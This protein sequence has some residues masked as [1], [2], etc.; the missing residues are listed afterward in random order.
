ML[1]FYR[2][3]RSRV[4]SQ[5]YY[6]RLLK[7]SPSGYWPLWDGHGA[8]ATSLITAQASENLLS[9]GTFET[10]GSTET[11]AGWIDR[12]G[13]GAIADEGSI[14]HA[15]SHACKLTRGDDNNLWVYQ[16]VVV[17]PGDSLALSLW[18]R[19][20]GSVGG[21]YALYDLIN[22]AWIKEMTATA[23]TATSYAQVQ[24]AITVPATC[25]LARLYL[26]GPTA[27][28]SVYFDDVTLTGLGTL[29]GSYSPSGVTYGQAGI[30]DGHSACSFSGTATSV[31]IGSKRF[32]AIWDPN[33][34]SAIAWGKIAASDWTD[35]AEHRYLF[36]PKS[37]A[38]PNY[39]IV[40]GKNG[41]AAH[42][43]FW[44]RKV[45]NGK[46]SNEHTYAFDPAGPDALWFCMGMTWD[47][48]T[49]RLRGYLYVPT[50]LAFTQVFDEAG[51]DMD[52]W[53]T[54]T[55]PVDDYNTCLMAGATQA[56][57]FVGSGA[58]ACYW[59]GKALSAA[60]MRHAMVL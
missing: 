56:Q 13:T 20:D 42:T 14:V 40:F 2:P 24:A 1:T 46:D 47:T 50:V 5:A 36:H 3:A 15:G 6:T 53:S 37:S 30:G 18:A 52:E 45:G 41:D 17:V 8:R 35:T 11:F 10:A 38:D 12:A 44:R 28:G 60:D 57:E 55:H 51:A 7:M 25:T 23:V 49:P 58:H 9:Y 31:L 54:T 26:A 34:G 29:H 48:T 19:G 16:D 22:S 33:L 59:G 32:N 21:R 27:A 39:Y 43:L 4:L